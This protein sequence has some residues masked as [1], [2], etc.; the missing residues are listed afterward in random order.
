M[1]KK[2]KS[3]RNYNRVEPYFHNFE[4]S[5]EGLN[6]CHSDGNY[7]YTIKHLGGKHVISASIARGHG[8]G[9]Q[10]Q[11]FRFTRELGGGYDMASGERIDG[12]TSVKS[13]KKKNVRI[14]EIDPMEG[15]LGQRSKPKKVDPLANLPWRMFTIYASGRCKACGQTYPEL[16][17]IAKNW[18]RAQENAKKKRGL[19]A[20][21]MMRVFIRF[22]RYRIATN[23]GGLPNP[24]SPF[25]M[26]GFD[27]PKH[28]DACGRSIASLFV[29]SVDKDDARKRLGKYGQ[30]AT[31]MCELLSLD[32]YI[33]Q[34]TDGGAP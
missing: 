14:R 25:R 16:F 7:P 33:I 4:H 31:C 28:L 1:I 32:R 3:P 13:K 2:R 26:F 19:C 24:I 11:W 21:D 23:D 29:I 8:R 20:M 27:V 18:E 9:G 10:P 15:V 22:P 30:C 12:P 6:H 5:P 17:T 34:T